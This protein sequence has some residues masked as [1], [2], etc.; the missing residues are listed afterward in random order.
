[1]IEIWSV[2]QRQTIH[3]KTQ[4]IE[5]ISVD[6][7]LGD[8]IQQLELLKAL[9]CAAGRTDQKHLAPFFNR[10]FDG[11]LESDRSGNPLVGHL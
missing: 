4:G 8:P 2:I 1:M 5:A 7:A 11:I 9:F 6:V 10:F 3:G